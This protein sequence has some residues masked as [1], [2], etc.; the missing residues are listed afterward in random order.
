MPACCRDYAVS[1]DHFKMRAGVTLKRASSDQSELDFN[2][3]IEIPVIIADTTSNELYGQAHPY[4]EFVPVTYASRE[5]MTLRNSRTS[6]G[7]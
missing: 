3:S 2:G 6:K 4:P 1:E 7:H 5:S